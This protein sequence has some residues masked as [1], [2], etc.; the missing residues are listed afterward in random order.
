MRRLLQLLVI[1]FGAAFIVPAIFAK[2]TTHPQ[3]S[4]KIMQASSVYVDCVCPRGLAAAQKA[5]S[6]HLLQWGR[7]HLSEDR[8]QSDLVLLFSGNPYL[9]DY[10]TRDGLDTRPVAIV[11]TI[12]TVIDPNTGEA[13]WT[14]SRM[15]GS[16][17]VKSATK[18]LIDELRGEMDSQ[19]KKWTLNEILMCGVTPVYAG[20]A[21]LTPDEALA[22]S[23]SGAGRA[24]GTTDRLV[25]TSPEAP[26]FCQRTQAVFT[27]EHRITG[28]EVI[29]SRAED[30]DVNDVLRSADLFAF[31]S[32]KYA[33]S[34]TIYFIA[35]SK[36]KKI[37]I[38]FDSDGHRMVFSSVSY[39]Y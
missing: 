24:S 31:T 19:V 18:D 39:L 33:D 15:W 13:L 28:Y 26:G 29:A 11:S 9:G 6:E 35:Q 17:R 25:L 5:A 4:A 23:D 7:F 1:V 3:L 2:D 21:R 16:L 30:L 27:P 10:L 14:D 12:M 20:F 32:G 38:Q 22:K 34:G 8:R 36:D 37:S